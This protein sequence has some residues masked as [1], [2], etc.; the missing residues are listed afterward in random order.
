MMNSFPFHQVFIFRHVYSV[1][2]HRVS[3]V[4]L[5]VQHT[6][7]TGVRNSTCEFYRLVE[8]CTLL[9]CQ[10]TNPDGLLYIGL[11]LSDTSTALQW[12]LPPCFDIFVRLL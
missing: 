5:T 6:F 10:G 11:T 2:L 8:N 7:C 12:A 9:F 4:L 1:H 3:Y